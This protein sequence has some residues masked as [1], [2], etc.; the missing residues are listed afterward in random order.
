MSK[1]LCTESSK[2]KRKK[3]NERL[4]LNF[5][6]MLLTRGSPVGITKFHSDSNVVF[7]DFSSFPSSFHLVSP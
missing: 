3:N 5:W 7:M 6:V 4:N 2:G 1:I